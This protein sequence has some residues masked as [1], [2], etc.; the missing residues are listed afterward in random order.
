MSC[1]IEPGFA[2]PYQGLCN[3][4]PQKF[5]LFSPAFFGR[6]AIESL[7][8]STPLAEFSEALGRLFV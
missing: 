5:E 2:P 8:V 7:V 6:A 1:M 4:Y 3:S